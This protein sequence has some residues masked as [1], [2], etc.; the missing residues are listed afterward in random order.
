MSRLRIR[1]L[2]TRVGVIMSILLVVQFVSQLGLLT[3]R[4]PDC[5][6]LRVFKERFSVKGNPDNVVAPVVKKPETMKQSDSVG[7]KDSQKLADD[8]KRLAVELSETKR[9]LVKSA[10]H[11]HRVGQHIE[12][13]N[14]IIKSLGGETVNQD[15]NSPVGKSSSEN[16]AS[17]KEVCPETFMGKS[18]DYG[19]PFFR[20]GF[21]RVNCTEFVQINQLVTLLVI[22]PGEL[23][24]KQQFHVFEG[25]ARYYPGISTVLASKEKLSDENITK[26]TLNL[27][28]MV[29]SD[30][31][32]G[33]TW[34]KLLQEVTTPYV[35]VAPDVTHFNDDI[36]LER[37]VRVL[38]DNKDAI[39][40]GG[41][42]RNLQGE[43]DIGCLQ[44][45][46]RNWTAFF[47]GGYYHSFA[48]CVVC[49]V[50]SGPFVAKT[51]GLRE[52]GIDQKLPFGVLQDV[53]WRL[54]S[55]H[56]EKVVVSCPDVMF[57][58][59]SREIPDE[60]YGALA[61]K[62]DVKKWVESNGRV[63][64][65]GCRRGHSHTSSDS[66]SFHSG[67]GV[68][69]CDLENLADA[70]KFV[71]KECEDAGLFCE[72]QEGTL[73]GAVKFNKVLPWERDADITFLTGNYTAFKQLRSKFSAAGYSLS[74]DDGSL[75][76]CVDGRQAGG[77]FRVGT[78]RWTL[79][80]YGQ[81][82]MESEALVASGQKPTKVL[83]A[84]QWVSVMRN[85]GLF[86]RNRYGPNMYQH[87]EHWM[88]VGHDTGWAFY[89]PSTFKACPETGHSACL[90]QFPADGNLQ[91]SDYPLL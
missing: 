39:V 19:Y 17:K 71:M 18:L 21:G 33:E 74:D 43:W 87:A 80:L 44:V 67:I 53:F 46:F 42:H 32:H 55:K 26:L 31:L 59:Y 20:K 23:S 63:R 65:Y 2:L 3:I 29:F 69:P 75:W 56:P 76:C 22:L 13:L 49:D 25:I 58:I 91:F 8:L 90:D 54:K 9:S 7:V 62:W 79:E 40:A 45:T 73:L 86:A 36:D 85:P 37:L 1:W 4:S 83:F 81:H 30:L 77:K 60:R 78:T 57:N 12:V 41:S 6:Q 10:L 89:R 34:S 68:P 27:K 35:L 28:N 88:D 50:L 61:R 5:E 82:M 11:Y 66:C 64:W 16:S 48:E 84:G 15:E 47:R 52:V 14:G 72:L 51:E 70:I 38:S 24:P